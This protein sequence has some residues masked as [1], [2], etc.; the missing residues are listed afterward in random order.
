[1]VHSTHLRAHS[2]H[3]ALF[4]ACRPALPRDRRVLDGRQD[5]VSA[6][7]RPAHRAAEPVYCHT[8]LDV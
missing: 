3:T 7:P 1:M 6:V 5:D 8:E 4:L 2:R